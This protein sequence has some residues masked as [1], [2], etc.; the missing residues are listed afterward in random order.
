MSWLKYRKSV[1]F[2]LSTKFILFLQL[3]G[4]QNP[5]M[6]YLRVYTIILGY[7][8]KYSGVPISSSSISLFKAFNDSGFHYY[9]CDA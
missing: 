5:P 9:L 2:S 7:D 3:P 6:P 1:Y 8:V 4:N